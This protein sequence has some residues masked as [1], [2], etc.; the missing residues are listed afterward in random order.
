MSGKLRRGTRPYLRTVVQVLAHDES[1]EYLAALHQE[2][3]PVAGWM[4]C[5]DIIVEVA[6]GIERAAPATLRDAYGTPSLHPLDRVLGEERTLEVAGLLSAV[7]REE[8]VPAH[9][10]FRSA[11]T[12]SEN[13]QREAARLK[14]VLRD[15]MAALRKT[16][17]DRQ[18][19]A[20]A[21]LRHYPAAERKG[22]LMYA[23]GVVHPALR[24][25]AFPAGADWVEAYLAEERHQGESSL[26]A[27]ERMDPTE[28]DKRMPQWLREGEED[29][30]PPVA[31]SRARR[32][33]AKRA[34][35][36]GGCGNPVCRNCGGY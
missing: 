6:R 11:L 33:R 34:G 20:V 16:G 18:A 2:L 15:C 14:P 31:G 21:A 8:G 19:G 23:A 17:G 10:A 9:V 12:A 4:S 36:R 26:A 29:P 22:A 24:W 3:F 7:G 5:L 28:Y 30:A 32:R 27:Y 13:I 35:A 25:F 1:M